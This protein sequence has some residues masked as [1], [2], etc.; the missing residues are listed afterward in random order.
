MRHFP[1]GSAS[2]LALVAATTAFAQVAA[3]PALAQT[4]ARNFNRIASFPVALNLPEGVDPLTVTSAEIVAASGDGMTLVYT[5]SPNKA[6]GFID[7]TDATSPAPLGNLGFDGEPTSVTILDQT[8][9]VGVNTR[10]SFTEPSGRLAAV[11]LA[12]RTETASCDLGGQPDSAVVARDGSFVVV[13]IENERDEDVNDGALPQ[14]PAGY[15]AIVPLTDGV[16]DCD[17]M[18]RADVTGLAGIAPT[19]PE[20]EYVDVNAAGEIAVTLQENNHI[21]ILGRD[22]AVKS[23]FSAGAVDLDGID[24]RDDGA[25]DFTDS[26]PARLREP[27]TVQW[28]DDNRLAVANEGDWTGGSRGFTVF[29]RDGSV[30]YESG[31]A[32]EQAIAAI[33]HYPDGR[34]DAKG[35]EPEGLE[36]ARFGDTDYLFVL[37][38]R[39]SIVGVYAIEDGVPTLSQLL[40]SGVSPEGA[41]AIPARNLLV[42]ANEVDL[43]EDGLARSHVMIYELQDAP[44]AYP[45]LTSAG[46]DPLIGWGALSGLAA[47]AEEPGRLYAVSDSV[48]DAQPRIFT[49]DATAAPARITAAIPITRGGQPAQKLDIEGIALDGDGGFWLASEGRG[50]RLIPHALYRVDAAGEIQDEIAFPPELLAGETRYGAEGIARIGEMLW[51]PIQREW[52]DDAKG[53]V[54]L[55]AYNLETEEWGAVRYPLDA[56]PEGG[57]VGLSEIAAYGDHVYLVERDNQV[58]ANAKIKQLTRVA[59]ADMVPAALDGDLPLVTKEVVRDF[60]PDL[61][62]GNGFILDKVEGFTIDAA[63]FGFAVTDNDGVD[64]SSG[65]TLF[66]PLGPLEAM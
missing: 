53:E 21:V 62:A 44:A 30:A 66:L 22:G 7:I 31:A 51:I 16:M 56:A 33:G 36:F 40:P 61:A 39:A 5:D 59:L 14:A 1:I 20:P 19:D 12:T 9:F 43:V 42:T 60:L 6:V 52:A 38:E 15:V 29:D 11:D 28:I 55:V 2:V 3:T 18:I 49:I 8:A 48:Y 27:D 25:L 47:A 37:A 54:K 63:G 32:F 65:E 4:P 50:D 41:T 45:A 13:A 34:S 10:A 57:W 26:Q 58:G 17:A 35:V 64:D 23:D 46:T 24:T